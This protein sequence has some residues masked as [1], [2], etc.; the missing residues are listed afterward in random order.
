M[1][2]L[3]LKKKVNC[4]SLK[5]FYN[6]QLVKLLIMSFGYCVLTDSVTKEKMD[7]EVILEAKSISNSRQITTESEEKISNCTQRR[8][9]VSLFKSDNTD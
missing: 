2:V 3:F 6:R 1:D 4:K 5:N 9:L 7:Q 8:F